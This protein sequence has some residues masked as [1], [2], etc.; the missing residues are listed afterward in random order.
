MKILFQQIKY[1]PVRDQGR[2]QT[3]KI[4]KVTNNFDDI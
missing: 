1:I 3:F 4:K 2:F